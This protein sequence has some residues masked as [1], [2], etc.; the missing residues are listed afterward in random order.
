MLRDGEDIATCPS[1]SL[2]IRVIF[3]PVRPL[4]FAGSLPSATLAVLTPRS[5]PPLRP[6]PRQLEW[7]DYED[8]DDEGAS[9]SDDGGEEEGSSSPASSSVSFHSAK[10][11]DGT[12]AGAEGEVEALAKG[13]GL[14]GLGKA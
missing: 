3:D 5:V 2:I 6:P 1:C 9:C 14:V 13:L 12:V 7:E 4:C 8:S 11:D 10:E